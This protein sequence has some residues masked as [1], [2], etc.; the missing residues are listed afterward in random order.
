MQNLVKLVEEYRRKFPL[1]DQGVFNLV[2]EYLQVLILKA[3]YQSKYGEGLSFMGGTCLRICHGIKRY[4]EDLDFALDAPPA[5]YSF[6][7]LNE[8]ISGFLKNTDFVVDL[9][10]QE[11]KVVQ[12]SFI[13]VSE[14]LHLF[15][16][17]PLKSQKIHIKLEVDTRPVL[18]TGKQR[19]TFFVNRFN[20]IFPILKHSDPT[21]FSGKIGAALNRAYTKGRDFY[22]L[23]WYLNQKIDIDFD[24]LNRSS[25]QAGLTAYFNDTPEV[26]EALK[27]RVEQTS[28]QEILKDLGWFLEDPSESEWLKNYDQVFGQATKQYLA[29][30]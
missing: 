22:D 10:I 23:I 8:V 4:S 24:Y 18:V 5:G 19:E 13:R 3:I 11:D 7:E 27:N 25:K 15:K 30:K 21:L 17:S 14:I 28:G 12:K 2:R 9:N 26:I 16:L 20:E 6:G 29:Q 1:G